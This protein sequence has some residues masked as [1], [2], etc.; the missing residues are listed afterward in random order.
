MIVYGNY[1][2]RLIQLVMASNRA[3]SSSTVHGNVG[4]GIPF[5]LPDVP[6]TPANSF[7]TCTNVIGRLNG[8]FFFLMRCS[9]LTFITTTTKAFK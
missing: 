8:Y 9:V 7:L 6:L 3:I 4:L 1:I 5:P 2:Y